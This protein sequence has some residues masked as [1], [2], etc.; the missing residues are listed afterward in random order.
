MKTHVLII[1]RTFPSY[2]LRKGKETGFVEKIPDEKIHT[3]RANY[4]LW[5]K[6]IKEVQFGEAVLSLRYWSDKPY[7]SEQV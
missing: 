4:P 6:R 7:K 5:E 2:H 1:S 3:I